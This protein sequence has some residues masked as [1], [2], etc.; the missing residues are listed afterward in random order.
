MFD[1]LLVVLADGLRPDAITLDG[2]P[3]LY[4]LGRDYV[5][6]RDAVTIRPSATVAALTSLATGASPTRHGFLSP[7]LAFLKTIDSLQPLPNVL[8]RHGVATHVYLNDVPRSHRPLVNVVMRISGVTRASLN[9]HGALDVA[10]AALDDDRGDG[11]GLQF[12]YMADAD[13]AGH[14]HGWMSRAYRD[15]AAVVDRA[16]G[17]LTQVPDTTLLVLADHGGGGVDP[18]DHDTPHPVNDRIPIILA[19]T[20][21][22]RRRVIEEPASILDIPPTILHA[23]GASIPSSY[24]GRPLTGAFAPAGVRDG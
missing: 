22:R 7:G 13:H 3:T 15:A 14:K 8:A 18:T 1:R 23:F 24:E 9:G 5:R 10:R 19:G 21:I 6:V 4:S 16:I 20:G 17:L 12:L 2:M 11:P